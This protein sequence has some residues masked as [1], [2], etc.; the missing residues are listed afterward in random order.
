MLRVTRGGAG[1]GYEVC[2]SLLMDYTELN[3]WARF[4]AVEFRV[5]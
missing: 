2:F 3:V 4:D 1:A 5:A